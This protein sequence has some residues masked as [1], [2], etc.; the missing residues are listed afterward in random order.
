MPWKGIA[1]SENKHEY[2]SNE[3]FGDDFEMF[4]TN[5]GRTISSTQAESRGE[6]AEWT[7][8]AKENERNQT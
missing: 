7:T 3:R 5:V 2:D 4:I 6:E 1:S 8:M